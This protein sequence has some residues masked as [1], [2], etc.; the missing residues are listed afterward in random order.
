MKRFISVLVLLLFLGSCSE[1]QK[2]RFVQHE[3]VSQECGSCP[4]VK[5]SY[6]KAEGDSRVAR[7]INNAIEEE[8]ISQLH[9]RDDID[10][11]SLEDAIRSF[12]A[13]PG[14]LPYE[15]TKEWEADLRTRVTHQDDEILTL[16]VDVYVYTGGAHGIEQTIYL[17][18]DKKRGE[19]LESW[20]LFH[21]N[22]EFLRLAE[23]EFRRQQQIPDSASINSTGY[24]FPGN[25]FDL[26]DNIGYS[27]K[28][29]ILHYN[30][31]EVASY[32]EG[33]VVVTI[34]YSKAKKY[35][36]RS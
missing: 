7:M 5:L 26:P 27:T 8:L 34:P 17:N 3:S 23:D 35:L 24:M 21:N 16:A 29:L 2:L 31:Y 10:V 13:T 32:A 11:Q 20:E 25:R 28:G 1:E 4:L 14:E 12:S 6:H 22:S 36:S 33:P 18:F 15:L 19:E 9:F 30:P